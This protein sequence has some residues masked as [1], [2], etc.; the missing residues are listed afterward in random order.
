MAGGGNNFR[1]RAQFFER[2][3]GGNILLVSR[4]PMEVQR[5]RDLPYL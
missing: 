2:P 4:L 1:R 3:Q 5:D